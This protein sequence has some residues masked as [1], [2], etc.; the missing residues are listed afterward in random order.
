[1]KLLK[2]T[3]LFVLFTVFLKS[4]LLVPA[5]SQSGSE[6]NTEVEQSEDQA[7]QNS[8]DFSTGAVVP[9]FLEIGDWVVNCT[10]DRESKVTQC[11]MIQPIFDNTGA[12]QSAIIEIFAAADDNPLISANAILVTP[13]GTNLEQGIFLQVDDILPQRNYRINYCLQNGCVA[14]M[15]FFGSEVEEM[16]NGQE[17]VLTLFAYNSDQPLG[18][19]IS[20]DGFTR[21]FEILQNPDLIRE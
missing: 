6:D 19:S 1:M 20:L 14:R 9:E 17:M 16:R 11:A 12:T 18:Y 2:S 3:L 15:A 7:T 4:M 5:Y 10:T 8:D 21:S 13:L